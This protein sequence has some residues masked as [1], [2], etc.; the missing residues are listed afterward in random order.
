MR[1]KQ[2]TFDVTV[3]ENPSPEQSKTGQRGYLEMVLAA[4]LMLGSETQHQFLWLLAPALGPW[5]LSLEHSSLLFQEI[6][7]SNFLAS[8]LLVGSGGPMCPCTPLIS[9]WKHEV[10]LGA[11]WQELR[12]ATGS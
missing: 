6:Q 1:R 4:M 11:L 2:W 12:M 10:I 7:L 5:L 3:K 8:F 9:L